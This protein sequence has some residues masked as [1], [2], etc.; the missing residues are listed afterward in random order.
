MGR[1]QNININ[2]NSLEESDSNPLEDSEG[3]KT[4]VTKVTADVIERA[5]D[6]ELEMKPEDVTKWLNSHDKNLTDE[7]LLLVDEQRK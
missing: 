5:R 2:I 1:R 6:T 4:S 3:F 7:E